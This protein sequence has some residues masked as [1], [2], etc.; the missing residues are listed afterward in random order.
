[1]AFPR[2]AIG[3]CSPSLGVRIM[4][5]HERPSPTAT[6]AHKKTASRM[7]FDFAHDT[8]RRALRLGVDLCH[9]DSQQAVGQD[10][11]GARAVDGGGQAEDADRLC[12]AIVAGRR[13][14]AEFLPRIFRGKLGRLESGG[15]RGLSCADAA[16][17]WA[18]PTGRAA[19][20][21]AVPA[22]AESR[23][24]DSLRPYAGSGSRTNITIQW[25]S[26]P[27]EVLE[28]VAPGTLASA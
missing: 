26:I 19:G 22:L 28:A 16:R 12:A 8:S 7:P 5:P 20:A 6:I 2:T 25:D 23:A 11:Y 17:H 24:S 27:T 4:F 18:W 10:G 21:D 9:A 14:H 3:E 13:L 1:M 15:V